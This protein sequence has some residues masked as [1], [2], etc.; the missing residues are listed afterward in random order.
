VD[1]IGVPLSLLDNLRM[2]LHLEQEAV[3]ANLDANV[4]AGAALY[5]LD[6]NYYG[7]AQR[8]VYER[9]G[10]IRADITT[11]Y[12]PSRGFAPEEPDCYVWCG[13]PLD[14]TN[15]GQ[16]T[17]LGLGLQHVRREG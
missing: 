11:H 4:P 1:W 12:A 16:T 13:R 7:D 3:L 6:V 17:A 9:A 14:L 2:Q 5:L 8:G 10:L 15:L